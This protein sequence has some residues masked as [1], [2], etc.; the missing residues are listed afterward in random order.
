MTAPDKHAPANV[1][2][3][4]AVLGAMLIDARAIGRAIEVLD[5]LLRGQAG[6]LETSRD[7]LGL[8]HHPEDVLAGNLLDVVVRPAAPQ[9][10]D[11]KCGELGDILE[12][13]RRPAD[14]VEVRADPHVVDPSD[15]A[16]VV[17]VVRHL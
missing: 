12:P 5:A 11:E 9:E 2:A 6:L 3:E 15:L 1:E 13:H 14:P 8:A 7:A 16:D 10:L 17:D 4:Q